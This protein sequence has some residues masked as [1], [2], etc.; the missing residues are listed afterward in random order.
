MASVVKLKTTDGGELIFLVQPDGSAGVRFDGIV[1]DCDAVQLRTFCNDLDNILD[2]YTH[3]GGIHDLLPVSLAEPLEPTMIDGMDYN[4]DKLRRELLKALDA[5]LC[6]LYHN[7]RHQNADQFPVILGQARRW[8]YR[9]APPSFWRE[10]GNF[11][12]DAILSHAIQV[13]P[14]PS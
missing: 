3:V 4:L 11:P 1:R 8:L 5:D 9:E 6:W 7:R 12:V 13:Q 10:F 2:S 14:I